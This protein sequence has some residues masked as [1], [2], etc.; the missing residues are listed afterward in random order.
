MFGV[1]NEDNGDGKVRKEESHEFPR[2]LRIWSGK[3]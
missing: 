1:G 2:E 3:S